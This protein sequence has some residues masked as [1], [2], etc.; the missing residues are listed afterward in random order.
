LPL[1]RPGR[2]QL[3]VSHLG[4]RTYQRSN[5]ALEVNTKANIDVRLEIG[6]TTERVEVTDQEAPISTEATEV[7]KVIDNTSIVRIPLNG[8]L[9][10]NGPRAPRRR[11]R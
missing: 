10:I 9:N 3:T 11:S 4:F 8:R 5:I 7:A 2:Y 1:L 6:Q